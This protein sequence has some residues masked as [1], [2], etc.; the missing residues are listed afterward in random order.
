MY[1]LTIASVTQPLPKTHT[2]NVD[3]YPGD[4]GQRTLVLGAKT[5]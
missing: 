2:H 4:S 1:C 5:P 3:L